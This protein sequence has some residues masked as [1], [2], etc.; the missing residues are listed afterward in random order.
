M[1]RT[2]LHVRSSI[3]SPEL[4][5][6]LGWS[7]SRLLN[8]K[9]AP[10]WSFAMKASSPVTGSSANGLTPARI[11]PQ[12]LSPDFTKTL[13]G[14][15]EGRTK[16]GSGLVSAKEHD[17]AEIVDLRRLN[18]HYSQTINRLAVDRKYFEV[19]VGVKSLQRRREE[20]EKHPQCRDSSEDT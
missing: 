17:F 6:S 20:S 4:A 1:M 14:V 15:K 11:C 3:F 8:N 18:T 10:L 19:I 2:M 16:S 5:S 7:L 9:E 12:M 13:L